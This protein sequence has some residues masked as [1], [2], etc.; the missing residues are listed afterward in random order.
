MGGKCGCNNYS[1][2]Y[3]YGYGLGPVGVGSRYNKYRFGYG[4]NTNPGYIGLDGL[5]SAED[6]LFYGY[7]LEELEMIKRQLHRLQRKC[8]KPRK[9]KKKKSTWASNHGEDTTTTTA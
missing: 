1:G 4:V 5:Y 6:I 9:F 2:N 8:G 7:Q 3:A